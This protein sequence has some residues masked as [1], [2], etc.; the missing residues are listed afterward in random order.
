MRLGIEENVVM[1]E[2]G[3]EWLTPVVEKIL[4]IR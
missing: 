3:V 4:L 2:N 1:T